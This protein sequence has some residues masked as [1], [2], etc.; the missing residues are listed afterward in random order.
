M[1]WQEWAI[2]YGREM[3]NYQMLLLFFIGEKCNCHKQ[4]SGKFVTNGYI[5]ELNFKPPKNQRK[6]MPRAKSKR[7]PFCGYKCTKIIRT[8]NYW[9]S[10]V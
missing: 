5:L 7:F 4:V 8:N 1:L 2:Y 10:N 9:T 6:T 3:L